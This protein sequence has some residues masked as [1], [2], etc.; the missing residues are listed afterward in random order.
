MKFKHLEI[1]NIASIKHAVVN[2]DDEPLKSAQLF[3]INGPTGAGKS[4]IFDSICLALFR[5]APRLENLGTRTIEDD[6]SDD[7]K[8]KLSSPIS[9]VRRGVSEASATLVFEGNN[10]HIY[11]ARWET[12]MYIKGEKKGSL[13]GERQYVTDLTDNTEYRGV[14]E[15][16]DLI[17]SN[18]V[19]GLDFERFTRTTMLAQGAFTR[20]LS[21]GEKEK[22]DI[23]RRIVGLDYFSLI[24][25]KISE[26]YTEKKRELD[27]QKAG[28]NSITFMDDETL[29]KTK[30]ELAQTETSL[31]NVKKEYDHL[32]RFI[33][34]KEKLKRLDEEVAHHRD[35]WNSALEKV[36]S[37]R[38]FELVTLEGYLDCVSPLAEIVANLSVAEKT[39]LTL[40]EELSVLGRKRMAVIKGLTALSAR[41]TSEKDQS[42]EIEKEL[43]S[44]DE[45]NEILNNLPVL[46]ENIKQYDSLVKKSDETDSEI[47]SLQKELLAIDKP[48]NDLIVEIESVET[49]CRKAIEVEKTLKETF[50]KDEFNR[51]TSTGNDL[52]SRLKNLNKTLE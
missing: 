26:I 48:I 30:Q 32:K 23:L 35:A 22:S 47:Q 52:T 14:T 5:T 24:G 50:D 9:F 39:K 46:K 6:M 20:F 43:K 1:K 21:A 8:L 27:A 13:K 45:Y 44:F 40:D 28:L 17:K 2:F 3:L 19:V 15:L 31:Q 10:G 16:K 4:V 33:D 42:A 18:D 51:L 38:Y 49:E 37:D 41:I 11:K 25:K 12:E 29:E 34:Y 36:T 7:G